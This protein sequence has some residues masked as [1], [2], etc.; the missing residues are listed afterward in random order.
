MVATY[1]DANLV[2]Q[3]VRWGTEMGLDDA[4][5]TLFADGFDPAQASIDEPAVRKMLSFGEVIGTLVKQ[6]VLDRGLVADSV[7]GY[8]HMGPGRA[9]RRAGTGASGRTK[10]LREL[11]GARRQRG[12]VKRRAFSSHGAGLVTCK[13]SN[14]CH[15]STPVMARLGP[16]DLE[17]LDTLITAGIAADGAEA[18]RSAL[19]RIRER[20]AYTEL[21]ERGREIERL[22][23]QF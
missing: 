23:T 4:V 12:G 17:T 13:S 8:G 2:V 6:G 18:V 11:R 21:R 5:H 14:L 15:G 7:V 9:C 10:A 19:A 1:D 3:L 22:K 20:P 16:V